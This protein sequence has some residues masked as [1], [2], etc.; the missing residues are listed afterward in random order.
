MRRPA[1]ALE[2]VVFAVGVDFAVGLDSGLGAIG[3]TGVFA[4]VGA[5]VG[6]GEEE[7]ASAVATEGV[8]T[9]G[10]AVVIAVVA[11]ANAVTALAAGAASMRADGR[12]VS[13]ATSGSDVV[14]GAAALGVGS[15]IGMA[16]SGVET[17]KLA[18]EGMTSAGGPEGAG[19]RGW[20]DA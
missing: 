7:V 3:L 18:T 17:C 12:L 8:E 2:A 16:G 14:S 10:S 20:A 9:E 19:E 5:A 13:T 15:G 4:C 11:V 1:E 6:A